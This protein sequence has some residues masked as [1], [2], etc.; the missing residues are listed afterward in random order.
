V[1]LCACTW[2]QRERVSKRARERQREREGEREIFSH[3]ACAWASLS[4]VVFSGPTLPARPDRLIPP[5]PA[6]SAAAT[7]DPSSQTRIVIMK[8]EQLGCLAVWPLTYTPRLRTGFFGEC[9]SE[10]LSHPSCKTHCRMNEI[11][12]KSPEFASSCEERSGGGNKSD[13]AQVSWVMVAETQGQCRYQAFCSSICHTS[14]LSLCQCG[15]FVM[16]FAPNAKIMTEVSEKCF[17]LRKIRV[18]SRVVRC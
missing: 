11:S 14:T 15:S 13:T 18:R 10:I 5:L 4:P 1:H 7:V 3:L 2:A 8:G 16:F 17:T 9:S 12:R 6:S